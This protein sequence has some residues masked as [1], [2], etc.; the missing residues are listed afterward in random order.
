MQPSSPSFETY[1]R[2]KAPLDTRSLH[3]ATWQLLVDRLRSTPS[4][5]ILEVGAGTGTMMDRLF[6]AGAL[7]PTAYWALEPQPE[8][9]RQA[10]LVLQQLVREFPQTASELVLYP[11]AMDW[12]TYTQNP[13]AQAFDLVMAH[14]FV[15]LVDAPAFLDSL[16]PYLRSGSLVYLS[17]IFDGLTQWFPT[18]SEDDELMARYHADMAGPVFNGERSG[19]RA[20]RLLWNRALQLGWKV[21]GIGPSDWVITQPATEADRLVQLWLLDTI[22]R[23]LGESAS[24]WIFRRRNQAQAG[25]LGL[26]VSHLDL[27]L[28]RP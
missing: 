6:R 5:R 14:A 21:L 15:D 17:L 2:A 25:Q 8:L 11:L 20:G 13:S 4:T 24:E 12:Q 27:L 3:P 28:E 18:L 9:L 22:H 7:G 1:L 26:R 10:G 19:P 16:L 23:V